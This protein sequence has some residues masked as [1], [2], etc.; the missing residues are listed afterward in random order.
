MV[1]SGCYR[2]ASNQPEHFVKIFM[3]IQ[4]REI[5]GQAWRSC[6]RLPEKSLSEAG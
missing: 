1:K 2:P 4:T 5:S 6:R 3:Q